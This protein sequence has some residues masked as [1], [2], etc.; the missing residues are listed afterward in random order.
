MKKK[1]N[2]KRQIEKQKNQRKRKDMSNTH[3]DTYTYK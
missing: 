1:Q 3:K 2:F